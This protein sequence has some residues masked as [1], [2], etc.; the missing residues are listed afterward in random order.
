MDN[1]SNREGWGSGIISSR[2]RC[3]WIADFYK[4][5]AQLLS[6]NPQ[7]LCTLWISFVKNWG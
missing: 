7:K 3:L 1:K 5:N 4:E 2:R 6:T